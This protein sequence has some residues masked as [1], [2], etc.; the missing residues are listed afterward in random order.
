MDEQDF[1]R[2]L[3]VSLF[4]EKSNNWNQEYSLDNSVIEEVEWQNLSSAEKHHAV[5]QEALNRYPG[6][7]TA[8]EMQSMAN[9][10]G[11]PKALNSQIHLSNIRRE[12]NAFYRQFDQA[13]TVPTKQQ[14]LDKAKAI[15]DLLGHLFNPPLR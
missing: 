1:F 7:L 14:L 9:L 5:E 10:R 6:V 15:D 4:K 12:W 11:I 13:G 8:N 2:D 3:K